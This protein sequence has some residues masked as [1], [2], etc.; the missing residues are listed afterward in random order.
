LLNLDLLEPIVELPDATDELEIQGNIAGQ[1]KD[2]VIAVETLKLVSGRNTNYETELDSLGV[3][4][5]SL[6]LALARIRTLLGS[7]AGGL[8]FNLF[9]IV[10]AQEETVVELETKVKN[11]LGPKI[12][13]IEAKLMLMQADLKRSR[14][15]TGESLLKRLGEL[16]TLVRTL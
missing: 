2:L 7:P 11:V 16:E 13:E 5:D 8:A 12:V 9:A 6:R 1:W 4:I 15:S 3:D 14:A 10:E